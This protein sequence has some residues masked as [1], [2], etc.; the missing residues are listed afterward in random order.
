MNRA[1][2]RRTSRGRRLTVRELL[3]VLLTVTVCSIV[4]FPFV[5]MVFTSFF[6][7]AELFDPT[8]LLPRLAGATFDN[9]RVLLTESNFAR[10]TLNSLIVATISMVVAVVISSLSGYAFSRFRF[11]GRRFMMVAII[12][13]Q[14]FPFVILITP[15]YSFFSELR[16]LNTYAGL[17]IAYVAI[18]LPFATYLMMGFFETVPR[19]LDE[20]ARVDGC[21]TLGVLFRVVLPV[22]WP[23]IATVAVNAFI[24]AWEE[25]LFAKVLVTNEGMK[26]VQVG[27]AQFFGEFVTRWD[28]VMSAS[29]L[30]SVPTIILF[31]I[32]QRR[33]VSGLAIG[34]VKE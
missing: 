30:A 22:A 20:A 4:A 33:L 3:V 15:L 24:L 27:L 29:V 9:Y 8:R 19:S 28:L 11:R 18:T 16:L 6:R 12:A 17:V 14:L 23:G 34:G 7:S 21:G 1:S 5:W 13:V 32:A 26:T 31:A 25:Y 10:Y 2:S